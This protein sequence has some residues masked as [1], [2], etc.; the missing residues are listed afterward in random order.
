MENIALSPNISSLIKTKLPTG[1]IDSQAVCR[2]EKKAPTANWFWHVFVR[3]ERV[4]AC[5]GTATKTRR[6]WVLS[7]RHDERV[8][9]WFLNFLPTLWKRLHREIRQNSPHT[10]HNEEI[11]LSVVSFKLITSSIYCAAVLHGGGTRFEHSTAVHR[12]VRT[13]SSLF[14]FFLLYATAPLPSKRDRLLDVCFRMH[15]CSSTRKT[16][17][18]HYV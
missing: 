5:K 18:F 9:T 16:A 10:P 11:T 12:R 15:F 13:T 4:P 7:R 17:F 6:Q 2:K 1:K 8:S 14:Y 3:L